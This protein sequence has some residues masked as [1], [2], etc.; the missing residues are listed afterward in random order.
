MKIAFFFT[1]L[2]M[3]NASRDT[4]D[5]WLNVVC[6]FEK[7]SV[8]RGFLKNVHGTRDIPHFSEPSGQAQ[9]AQK[10]PERETSPIFHLALEQLLR[11][12]DRPGSRATFGEAKKTFRSGMPS[13]R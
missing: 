4:G 8:L 6:I 7:S 10:R 9:T 5:V 11:A 13:A 1:D 3:T 2:S 12:P